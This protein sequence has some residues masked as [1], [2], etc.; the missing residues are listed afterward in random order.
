MA[1]GNLRIQ[2]VDIGGNLKPGLAYADRTG[3]LWLD[4]RYRVKLPKV[5]TPTNVTE[6]DFIEKVIAA[7]KEAGHWFEADLI[8]FSMCGPMVGAKT[9]IQLI[10]RGVRRPITLPDGMTG[11]NDGLAAL[12]GSQVAGVAKGHDGAVLM[13]TLGTGVGHGNEH[14]DPNGHLV[15][16]DAEAH[17]SVRGSK[18]RCKCGRHCLEAAL[19]EAAL[20]DYLH[21]K[22][23]DYRKLKPKGKKLDIGKNMRQQIALDDSPY[24]AVIKRVLKKW[25]GYMADGLASMYVLQNMGGNQ[26]QPP[27]L[28]VL[29]GGLAPLVDVEMLRAML[30][31]EFGGHPFVGD[32]FEIRKEDQVGNR[33]G[34]IGAAAFALARH[35]RKNSVRDIQFLPNGPG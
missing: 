6:A 7:L 11:I 20:I 2:F 4:E 25:H 35:L 31:E 21:E 3:R 29:G 18:R 33:A 23:V 10:N 1:A 28:F 14:W 27:A 24:H 15:S 26:I 19:Q 17:I 30:L 12:Y 32:N 34:G 16:N 5:P 9:C 22:G 8:A 13:L